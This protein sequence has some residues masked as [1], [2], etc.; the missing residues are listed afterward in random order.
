[1]RQI[2][3]TEKFHLIHINSTLPQDV[4]LNF[5]TFYHLLE[6]ILDLVAKFQRIEYGKEN[7]VTLQ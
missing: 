4:K 5:T 6:N 3:P 2:F 7:I 1:M